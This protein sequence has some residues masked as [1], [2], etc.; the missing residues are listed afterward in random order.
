MSSVPTLVR[1]DRLEDSA[2]YFERVLVD[3]P[4]VAEIRD[5]AS[6]LGQSALCLP[7]ARAVSLTRLLAKHAVDDRDLS[8]RLGALVF[9]LGIPQ[10]DLDR[11]TVVPSPSRQRRLRGRKP[12]CEPWWNWETVQL[13]RDGGLYAVAAASVVTGEER[14]YGVAARAGE[15]GELIRMQSAASSRMHVGGWLRN[16]DWQSLL[17]SA[18]SLD[19]PY[20][21][22]LRGGQEH[23]IE[24]WLELWKRERWRTDHAVLAAPP[25]IVESLIAVL[26]A[27][28]DTDGF[29]RGLHIPSPAA[30]EQKA[31]VE[32]LRESSAGAARRERERG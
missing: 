20:V 8:V 4:C 3:T 15:L 24:V 11:P 19:Y 2:D 28:P 27:T 21:A 31:T 12:R 25:P 18:V 29:A 10:S 26:T 16:T 6:F 9:D 32:A 17:V 13:R 23:A 5:A 7:R 14:S 1:R 22:L 30:D